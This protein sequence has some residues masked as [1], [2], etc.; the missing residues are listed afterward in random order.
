MSYICP[1]GYSPRESLDVCHSPVVQVAP[2]GPDKGEG[3]H[4]LQDVHVVRDERLNV[5]TVGQSAGH[6]A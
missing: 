6:L 5:G 1:L 3:E 4:A 2:K